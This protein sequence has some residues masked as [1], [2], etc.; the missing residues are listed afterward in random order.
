MTLE[1]QQRAIARLFANPYGA[2]A[3]QAILEYANVFELP[4]DPSGEEALR[5][6]G[7]RGLA[8]DL[9]TMAGLLPRVAGAAEDSAGEGSEQPD[10][11]EGTDG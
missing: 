5:D 11:A 3:M 8:L 7:A 1:Q 4:T 2:D 9:A 10:Q 6:Q